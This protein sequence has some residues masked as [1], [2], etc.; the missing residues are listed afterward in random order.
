MTK[1]LAAK[2]ASLAMLISS[3]ALISGCETSSGRPEICKTGDRSARCAVVVK[4]KHVGKQKK[5]VARMV[6]RN[7]EY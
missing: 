3:A 5:H 6:N 2:M 4:K 7:S 1:F